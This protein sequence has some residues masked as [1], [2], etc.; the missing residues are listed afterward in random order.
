MKSRLS[1]VGVLLAKWLF[2]PVFGGMSI[3]ILIQFIIHWREIKGLSQVWVPLLW[4]IGS[5]SMCWYIFLQKNVSVDEEFLYIK[6]YFKEVAIPLS[7]IKHVT[8]S[9]LYRSRSVTVHLKSP[10]VFGSKI[11]FTPHTTYRDMVEPPEVGALRSL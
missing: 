6:N 3:F 4:V 1:S 2:L 8:Y 9:R 10:S 7:E 5:L 11:R